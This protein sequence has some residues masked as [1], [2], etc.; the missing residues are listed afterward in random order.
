MENNSWVKIYRK[1]L[2]WEWYDDINTKVLF[3]HILL[4]ANFKEKKWRG[5]TIKRGQ[6]I[7]GRFVLSKE[8]GLSEQ[9]VRTSLDKL[10]STNE[11]TKFSTPT[12]TILTINNYD[13]Y[14]TN[15]QEDNQRATN[16]Q[17]SSNQVV[18]TP[19]ESKKDR[20][21]D[22]PKGIGDKSQE[23]G[24]PYLN[25]LE[26]ALKE[27]YPVP[28]TGVTDRRKLYNLVQVLTKRKNRDDWMEDDWK[29]NLSAFMNMYLTETKEEYY[30][31]SLDSL[32]EKAKLWRE[33]N[34]KLN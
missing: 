1:F 21:I 19:K 15:N 22:I 14:Q 26:K 5:I 23:Y 2:E 7:T 28:L 11:I 3:L 25:K 13:K 29:K 31:R 20:K 33:Y 10:I 18:T 27:R 8:T 16:E 12:Y 34:G 30:C 32:R 9:Q 24:N 6:H 17:P 4:K